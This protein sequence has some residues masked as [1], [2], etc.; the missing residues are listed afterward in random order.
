MLKISNLEK[1]TLFIGILEQSD[2]LLTVLNG[3]GKFLYDSWKL[4]LEKN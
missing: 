4:T 2:V 1:K 3:S